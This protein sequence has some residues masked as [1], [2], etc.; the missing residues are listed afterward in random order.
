MLPQFFISFDIIL[1]FILFI[2]KE[3]SVVIYGPQLHTVSVII[4]IV[5]VSLLQVIGKIEFTYI[6]NLIY[7]L[8]IFLFFLRRVILF[9][10][11]I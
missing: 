5:L 3:P 10:N 11:F 2:D 4:V 9:F 8:P 1:F 6:S 7:L